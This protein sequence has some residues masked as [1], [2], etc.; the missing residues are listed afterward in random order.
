M[1]FDRAAGPAAELVART[2][3]IRHA[4]EGL[5]RDAM[6]FGVLGAL[7]AELPDHIGVGS[8][9][10]GRED[11]A[12]RRFE[13][14]LVAVCV[15]GD[16]AGH[17]AGVVLGKDDGFVSAEPSRAQ[18]LGGVSAVCFY[19]GKAGDARQPRLAY[20]LFV[21]GAD[22]LHGGGPHLV[23]LDLEGIA[24]TVRGVVGDLNDALASV[25]VEYGGGIGHDGCEVVHH[26]A[27]IADEGADDLGVA[28]AVCAADV[29]VDD[30]LEVIGAESPA[31]QQV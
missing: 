23:S 17:G 31:C 18:I 6:A 5:A 25:A 1:A 11:D 8:E 7:G 9:V 30:L 14:D 10:A 24:R 22:G 13:Q 21:H 2:V 28:S 16:H 4:L 12:L 27:R 3:A 29:L 19:L 15:L 26:L 20:G